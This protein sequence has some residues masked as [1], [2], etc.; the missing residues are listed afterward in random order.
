MRQGVLL[1]AY[2]GES[3][4]M[5]YALAR[6]IRKWN[7]DLAIA[8]LGLNYVCGLNWGRLAVVRTV[9]AVG[10]HRT[11]E[12]WFNKLGAL[13]QT[14]FEETL[15]LDSDMVVMCD[16]H[17]WMNYL[18]TDDL[19]FF[20]VLLDAATIPDQT[21]VNV[22]NPHRMRERY[23]LT[24]TAVIDAG[25]HFLFRNTP[26][27]RRLLERIV[28]VM[29]E[30]LEKG[31]E[32]LYARLAGPGNIAASDEIAASIVAVEE[33]IALPPAI[34]GTQRPIGIYMTPAQSDGR[35]DFEK[36]AAQYHDTWRGGC[37]TASAVHFCSHGKYN[38]DYRAWVHKQ[39]EDGH[40]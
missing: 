1:T 2:N 17:E 26:R 20:N 3:E 32:S 31:P 15:Y 34:I 23:A 24:A 30:A 10:A 4:A 13:S 38:P 35:F 7:R 6:G 37:V 11:E 16:L 9:R 19:T 28:E 14:P 12:K 18:R 21:I 27:G 29:Q 39:V 40:R 5:A 36:G 22:V 25:G 33:D 8:V